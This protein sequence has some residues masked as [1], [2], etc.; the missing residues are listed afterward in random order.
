LPQNG[1]LFWLHGCTRCTVTSSSPGD[2]AERW[3]TLPQKKALLT[4][5]PRSYH[6]QG[7][8]SYEL[9]RLVVLRRTNR[10]VLA[11]RP[12]SNQQRAV[13]LSGCGRNSVV[14]CQLPK[15]DVAGS[16]PVARS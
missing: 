6:S 3:A 13:V 15:L 7:N 2:T 5:P 16:N 11:R 8:E 12:Q 4:T 9:I 10:A 1:Q 14:E